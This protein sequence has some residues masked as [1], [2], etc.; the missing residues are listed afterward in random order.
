MFSPLLG[1]VL[2]LS[3]APM[4]TPVVP[5]QSIGPITLGMTEAAIVRTG[6]Q[7]KPGRFDQE[8]RVGVFDVTFTDGKVSGVSYALGE[9]GQPLRINGT[10]LT[11][12]SPQQMAALIKGCTPM[13]RNYGGNVIECTSGATIVQHMGGLGIRVGAPA[14]VTSKPTC[15]GY[16]EPGNPSSS[17][18]IKPGKTYCLPTRTVTT[19]LRPADVLGTLR[20]N[21]CQEEVAIGGTTITCPF[22]GTQFIFAGPGAVLHAVKGVA[23]KQ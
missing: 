14:A 20:Y 13:Q 19:A 17:L 22:Q 4:P 1:P 11:P 21:T 10:A 18:E 7:V 5:G 12:K 8:R 15:A 9:S 23:M 3:I 16:L 6:I 2:A